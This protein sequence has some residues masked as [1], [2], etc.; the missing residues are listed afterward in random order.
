MENTPKIMFDDNTPHWYVALGDRWGGPFTATEVYKQVLSHEITWAH[1]VWKPGQTE[2][3][4]ICDLKTF[5]SAVPTLPGKEVKSE[6]KQ[7]AVSPPPPPKKTVSEERKWFVYQNDTQHGP[8]SGDEIARF[9][10]SGR[11]NKRTYIWADGMTNWEALERVPQ[12]KGLSGG[13]SQPPARGK[14]MAPDHRTAPRRPL[15]AKIVMAN[16]NSVNVG[17]CRDISIGGMQVLTDKIPGSV[18]QKIKFNVSST[19]GEIQP[20]VAQGTIVRLLEDGRGFS[21]RFHKITDAAI[22]A[23]ETYIN[24]SN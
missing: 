11:I 5:Q 4:R 1:Y 3:K 7:A 14:T 10:K 13:Q 2:W 24:G 16:D 18:G 8:F 12:L 21:F 22:K 23:V 9:L 17:M 15:L 19:T 20:F 6:V